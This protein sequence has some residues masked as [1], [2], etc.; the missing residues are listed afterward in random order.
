MLASGFMNTPITKS[1]ILSLISTSLVASIADLK[2]LLPIRPTPHLYPYLQFWRL[3]TWQIAYTSST[4][5]LFA[6]L[7]LYQFRVLER[8][9][10]SRKFISFLCVSAI[11]TGLLAPALLSTVVR[12]VSWG[13]W[14]Y[15][16]GGMTGLVFAALA[17]WGEEVPRLYRYKIVTGSPDPRSGSNDTPGVILS[18]KTT[19]YVMAAQLALSQF[20]YSLLAASVG[21]IVGL[22]WDGDLLPGRMNAWRIPRWL[23]GDF[24]V[25]SAAEREC[26]EGLRRRLEEEG[27][28]SDGMRASGVDGIIDAVDGEA[29]RRPMMRQVADYFRGAF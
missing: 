28:R 6:T 1:L 29:R 19:T 26:Y 9:W 10:G 4:D 11:W 13:R 23:L 3:C 8:L 16:P 18:D 5:L 15:L 12:L 25:K 20:P 14:N 24:G 22:A 17:A 21:W 27:G 7:L 2:H